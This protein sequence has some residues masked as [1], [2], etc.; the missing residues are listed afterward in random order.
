MTQQQFRLPSMLNKAAQTHH[1]FLLVDL[2]TGVIPCWKRFL[3]RLR[4]TMLKITRWSSWNKWTND[5]IIPTKTN[6]FIGLQ[7]FYCPPKQMFSI[8]HIFFK[9]KKV[10]E[11]STKN[12]LTVHNKIFF[13]WN[14]CT[15]STVKW[16]QNLTL[17]LH[18]SG[19]MK[20]SYSFSVIKSTR[21]RFP[22]I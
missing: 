22:K 14:T 21:P 20:R 19:L 8:N 4:L 12:I 5:F 2:T 15:L 18:V 3:V 9:R 10:L 16:N 13:N 17:G 1:F 7:T 6:H 11:I